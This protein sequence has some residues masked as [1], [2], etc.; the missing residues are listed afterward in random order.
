[1]YED[2]AVEVESVRGEPGKQRRIEGGKVS[3][4]PGQTRS[5]QEGTRATWT[6]PDRNQSAGNRRPSNKKV[7]QPKD[8]LV[9][10]ESGAFSAEAY[11]YRT[12]P[13]QEHENVAPA[14]DHSRDE[15]RP[16]FA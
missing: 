1:V 3:E 7:W 14:H 2:A 11:R 15:P 4:K 5:N 13:Q 10:C 6:A 8:R 12:E 16:S 9:P